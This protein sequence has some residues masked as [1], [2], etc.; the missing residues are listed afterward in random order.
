[1]QVIRTLT[2]RRKPGYQ[3]DSGLDLVIQRPASSWSLAPISLSTPIKCPRACLQ[4]VYKTWCSSQWL[5]KV[6]I[7][8]T[9]FIRAAI[10]SACNIQISQ[11]EM[12]RYCSG[13]PQIFS[14]AMMATTS[15]ATHRFSPMSHYVAAFHRLT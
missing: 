9:L 15:L 7:Y 8:V 2:S 3:W 5:D 10:R 4:Y 11:D 6:V 12:Q 1:M 13:F 14:A